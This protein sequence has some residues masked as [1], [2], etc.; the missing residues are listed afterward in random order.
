MRIEWQRAA[1][2]ALLG[3]ECDD[4]LAAVARR[5]LPLVEIDVSRLERW[6]VLLMFRLHDEDLRLSK[7]ARC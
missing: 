7:R 4:Q 2:K 3:R 5:Q 1:S 6:D